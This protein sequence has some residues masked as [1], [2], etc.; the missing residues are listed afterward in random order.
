MANFFKSVSKTLGIANEYNERARPSYAD[1]LSEDGAEIIITGA[2]I[3]STALVCYKM[4][5]S[6]C[7]KN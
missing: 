1:K 7:K 4:I 5:K 2:T 3:I 6:L